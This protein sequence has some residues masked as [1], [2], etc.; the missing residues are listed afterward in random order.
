MTNSRSN[1]SVSLAKVVTRSLY[2]NIF[3][4]KGKGYIRLYITGNY[5]CIYPRKSSS[6]FKLMFCTNLSGRWL[7]CKGCQN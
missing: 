6:F 4:P 7:G 1:P 2:T 5:I 3:Q